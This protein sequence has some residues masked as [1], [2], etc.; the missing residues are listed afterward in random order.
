MGR[1]VTPARDLLTVAEAAA[2]AGRTPQ[3]LRYAIQRG[4]LPAQRFGQRL[5]MVAAADVDVYLATQRDRR[6]A[7]Q[8]RRWSSE[9]GPVAE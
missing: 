2:R 3:A 9:S 1:T 5:L 6:I 7:G 8:R 4:S